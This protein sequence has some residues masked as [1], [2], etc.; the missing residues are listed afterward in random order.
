MTEAN[1]EIDYQPLVDR[2]TELAE[3]Q[4]AENLVSVVLYGSVARGNAGPLSDIDILVV[5]EEGSDVYY[6]RLEPFLTILNQIRAESAGVKQDE[7]GLIPE[8]SVLILT[9]EESSENKY[10]YLDMIE[11]AK[12]LYDRDEFFQKRLESLADRLEELGS[13]RVEFNGGWYWDLKPDLK[14]GEVVVL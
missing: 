14:L 3:E 10:L 2:F 7:F 8:I 1:L 5:I 6:E 11:E 12:I 4:I 13:R 9:R